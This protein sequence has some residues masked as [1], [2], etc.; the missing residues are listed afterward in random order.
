M[1]QNSK[2]LNNIAAKLI[3]IC[4]TSID[5]IDESV[6][7][8]ILM[9]ANWLLSQELNAEDLYS[10]QNNLLSDK[11]KYVGPILV[12]K[13]ALSKGFVLSLDRPLR[14]S[15]VFAMY[16]EHNRIKTQNEHPHGENFLQRK[17]GQLRW[18]FDEKKNI[19]FNLIP[20]DDGCPE[21]SGDI[22]RNITKANDLHENVEVLFL[23]DAIDKNLE[24][25]IGLKSTADSQ[26]G[27]SIVYGMWHAVDKYGEQDH[28]VLYTDADL[29]TH[30]GQ[31]GLL[32]NPILKSGK[33]AAIG[34]RRETDS[35][36]LKTGVR[37]DRGKLFIYLWKRLI[38]NLGKIIDTQCGFKAFD[39]NIVR[40]ITDNLIEKKFAFDIEL[41]LRTQ[42]IQPGSV[43]KVGIAWLDSE[44]ASTTTDLQPYLSMLKAIVKMSTTY[45]ESDESRDSF[46]A[47]ING[48]T[49]DKFNHLLEKIPAGI[50]SRE[51][52]EFTSYDEVKASD[53]RALID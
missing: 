6:E 26:K 27:G 40:Q 28:L 44:A 16:K 1:K 23:K 37:N 50:T 36:V 35:V 51:P 17:V 18:L 46:A 8:Q 3:D 30:L 4:P 43:E 41:L 31:V 39:G 2:D 15:V 21:G 25:A 34:S 10:I 49:D 29:S 9:A 38:P 5:L 33:L 19:T 22:A 14:V 53:L 42:S 45:F 20:V 11:L 47:F 32:V 12:I 13:L 52:F 7:N 24:G 48:L